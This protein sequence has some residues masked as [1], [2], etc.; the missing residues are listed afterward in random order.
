MKAREIRIGEKMSDTKE[1]GAVT[2]LTTEAF[3]QFTGQDGLTVID[4]WAS[5]CGPCIQMAPQ[6]EKAAELRPDYHFAKVNVDEEPQLAA[7]YQVS[8]I[9]TLAVLRDGE[10]LGM[11]PGVVKARELVQA[12]D[13]LA[14]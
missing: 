8:S 3:D 2:S 12:L 5:W 6:F 9:P 13:K 11:A 7:K 10:L 1:K 4:F 14:G